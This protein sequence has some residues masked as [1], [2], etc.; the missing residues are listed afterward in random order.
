MNLDRF[1][2]FMAMEII[3]VH[4]DGYCMFKNNYRVYADP[5][6]Q[7]L[8][9]F[10][11]GMDL[12]FQKPDC[13]I[14]PAWD[15]VI[16]RGLMETNEG[17]R[18]YLDRLGYLATNVFSVRQVQQRIRQLDVVVRPYFLEKS[19]GRARA[20]DQVVADLSARIEERARS[21]RRQLQNPDAF[22]TGE[23]PMF[24]NMTRRTKRTK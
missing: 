11:H 16:A 20:H 3:T 9:F 8:E 18:L 10:P 17:K 14:L 21:L 5:G 1:L 4:W 22:A 6:A 24:P 15:G 2:S 12:M 23:H 19:P 13:S 7:R